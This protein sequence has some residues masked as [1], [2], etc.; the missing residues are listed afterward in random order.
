MKDTRDYCK[1]VVRAFIVAAFD[2]APQSDLFKL[3]A[4]GLPYATFLDVS[5]DK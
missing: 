1:T 4:T 3:V 5:L 2:L